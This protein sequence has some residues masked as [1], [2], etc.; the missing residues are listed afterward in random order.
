MEA[1]GPAGDP[2]AAIDAAWRRRCREDELL[3]RTIEPSLDSDLPA[4]LV[5]AAAGQGAGGDRIIDQARG[6]IRT[7]ASVEEVLRQLFLLGSVATAA[8]AEE[9]KPRL[10]EGLGYAAEAIAVTYVARAEHVSQTD[11]LTGLPND[12]VLER[13]LAGAV[14]RVETEGG[15]FAVAFLDLDGLKVANDEFGGHLAG[16]H[17]IKRFGAQ[18]LDA[19]REVRGRVYRWHEHGDEFCILFRDVTRERV[20]RALHELRDRSD[21]APF[22]PDL[23]AR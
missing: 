9:H 14:A 8:L 4:A 16:D 15:S 19:V 12:R 18:L 1:H 21:V 17:Y 5:E 22:S 7:G 23:A 13:D 3:L 20:E 6:L 2:V 11:R 10:V